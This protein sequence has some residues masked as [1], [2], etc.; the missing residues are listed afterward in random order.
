MSCGRDTA[1]PVFLD[2]VCALGRHNVIETFELKGG[3]PIESQSS[4]LRTA[5]AKQIVL[6]RGRTIV[7]LC[8]GAVL[9]L[10][11]AMPPAQAQTTA[12]KM[13][14]REASASLPPNTALQFG[15]PD[16]GF[17]LPHGPANELRNGFTVE[18]WIR[19]DITEGV[20]RI[21]STHGQNPSRGYGLGTSGTAVRFTTFG[22]T[23][24]D[25]IP[26]FA[27][28]GVWTHVAV[29]FDTKNAATFYINGREAQ[30]IAGEHPADVSD[31]S[32]CLGRCPVG[33]EEA[34]LGGIDEVRIW[35]RVRSGSEIQADAHAQL[36]GDEPGLIAY[37]PFSEGSGE[38]TKDVT[39]NVPASRLAGATWI[40]GPALV[41][42]GGHVPEDVL[43][44]SRHEG[45][46]SDHYREITGKWIDSNDAKMAKSH[47]PGLTAGTT[48]GTRKVLLTDKGRGSANDGATARFYPQTKSPAAYRVYVT[49]PSG[50]N[51][52]DVVYTVHHSNG[53]STVVL[54]QNGWGDVQNPPCNAGVWTPLGDYVFTPGEDQYVEVLVPKD[55]VSV[56]PTYY[57]QAYSDAVL[58]SG[59]E[60]TGDELGVA[61]PVHSK[62]E[63]STPAATPTP[64]RI[65]ADTEK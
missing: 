28:P 33:P 34:W 25:T 64:A 41:A 16:Q 12:T 26:G 27:V 11:A 43:V 30:R 49:W 3:A 57:G 18:A 29:V 23:D 53:E 61:R 37:Y 45:K 56:D 24:Y 32:M 13:A 20:H 22:K 17:E 48:C 1:P 47:A 46:G 42:S 63:P 4:L 6:L 31:T 21:L 36:S 9:I 10:W 60:L 39:S 51:A 44:E 2:S 62:S 15:K 40:A 65:D 19:P 38:Y 52:R 8:L 59:H 58:F 7:W 55:C 50:A 5:F 14:A 54:S 35:D